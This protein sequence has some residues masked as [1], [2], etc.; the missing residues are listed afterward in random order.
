MEPNSMFR[1]FTLTTDDATLV[2][3]FELKEMPPF[4]PQYNIAPGD[5][6]ATVPASMQRAPRIVGLLD[7]GLIFDDKDVACKEDRVNKVH[8]DKLSS[9]PYEALF[10][11]KRCLILADGLYVWKLDSDVP[12]YLVRRDRQPFAFAGIRH[13]FAKG[14]ESWDTCAIIT[15]DGDGGGEPAQAMPALVPTPDFDKWIS[16]MVTKVLLLR[17][18]LTPLP[19]D[20]M[21]SRDVGDHVKDVNDKLPH[22]VDQRQS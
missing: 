15:I 17:K 20:E 13:R 2:T 1:D 3:R 22:C 7:W 4:A 21:E 10:R 6:V 9:V 11:Y 8:Q 12:K 19:L 18:L 16:P 5:R 14:E